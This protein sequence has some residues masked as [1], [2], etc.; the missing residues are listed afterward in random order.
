MNPA[1]R[2]PHLKEIWPLIRPYWRGDEKRW[3]WG[4]LL[5]VVVLNL[6]LIGIQVRLNLWNNTFYNTLQNYD[7][8][9]FF[10]ALL[11]FAAL[12]A[13]FIVMAVYSLYLQ[14]MLQIRWRRWLT[15][16]LLGDWL[17]EQSYYRIGQLHPPVDNP[18]QRLAE[19]IDSFTNNTLG[20]SLGLMRA[21][22]T[23][24]SFLGILWGLSGHLAFSL[25]GWQIDIP[26]YMVWVAL[27][28]AVIGSCL[29]VKIGRP[30]VGLNFR[31]QRFEADFRFGLIRVR[32]NAESIAL[33]R[34]ETAERLELDRRFASLFTNFYALMKRQKLLTWFTAAYG[35]IA[36]VF[37]ILV[38]APRYFAREM[39]LGGLMQTA[40]AFGQVQ[41]SLSWLVDAYP[42]LA[43]WKA[44][45]DRLLTF[46]HGIEAAHALQPV[47]AEP[48]AGQLSVSQLALR[49]PD[50]RF[51]L[52]DIGFRLAEGDSLW[53][54]GPSGCGKSTLLKTLAGIW[55]HARGHVMLPAGRR[56]LFLS[57]RPYLPLG[58]LREAF[59]YPDPVP[60]DDDARLKSVMQETGLFH[61]AERLDKVEPWSHML[62]LGEQQRVALARVLLLQ[63]DILFLDEATSA[64]DEA[65][66]THLYALVGN[67]MKKGI[68]VSVGHRPGL[69]PH[70]HQQL[71]L[72]QFRPKMTAAGT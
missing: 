5:A 36:I 66:E 8:A 59:Y 55:P 68:L 21:V 37:P 26:G 40:S 42:R 53:L 61:L 12:A 24:F 22:V 9:G 32:E 46:R 15:F 58:S 45:V 19:D 50:Q 47:V 29:T 70:H 63:P 33:Y 60:A 18:D 3:A 7:Q 64:L 43:D 48:S 25:A 57:Q 39:P 23:L 51:L 31:Q 28:Y 10:S 49:T 72:Q 11:E 2:R 62:S 13:G 27:L 56:V 6:G 4:L 16:H 17:G 54:R 30:L 65:M 69:A 52:R 67:A 71:N 14:Q 20:L 1:D 38:A 41:E 34:G 44:T 35:Q